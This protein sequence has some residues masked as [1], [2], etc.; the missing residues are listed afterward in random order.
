MHVADMPN[1]H[2]PPIDD[3]S[4]AAKQEVVRRR[5]VPIHITLYA[6][7]GPGTQPLSSSVPYK[8]Y[9]GR[10][11]T[12]RWT[13]SRPITRRTRSKKKLVAFRAS[14]TSTPTARS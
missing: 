5:N 9:T 8:V 10:C 4:Y 14:R 12:G 6:G 13:T 2:V 1:N 7:I 11:V 3:A